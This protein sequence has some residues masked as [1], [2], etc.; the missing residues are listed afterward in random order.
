M[1]RAFLILL[2]LASLFPETTKAQEANNPQYL[3]VVQ[4]ELPLYPAVAKT[5]RLSGSVQ[6]LVIVKDGEV[7]GAEAISGNPLLVSPTIKNIKTWKFV[8]SVNATFTTTFQY[9][10]EEAEAPE[11]SNPKIELE[12]PTLVKITAKPT[13]GPCHDCGTN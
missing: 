10:L 13:K 12:L 11:P 9:R 6:V 8:K 5:A 7:T 4:G 2:L 1:K 3:V